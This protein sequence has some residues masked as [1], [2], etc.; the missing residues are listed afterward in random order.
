V[1][2]K[3]IVSPGTG[4]GGKEQGMDS[5]MKRPIIA[6][7]MGDPAGIGPEIILKAIADKEVMAA[8]RPLVI[9]D[10]GVLEQA[11]NFAGFEGKIR[12]VGSPNEGAYTPST[13]DL[14]DLHNVDLGS[15]Q[16]GA[17]QAM[18]GRAAFEYLVKAVELAA[19]KLVAAVTTA[20]INKE[21]LRAAKINFIG[22][23]EIFAG[24]TGVP[25]P[26]TMFQVQGLKVFFLSR[27]VSL[28]RACELVT[29]ERV[30]QAITGCLEALGRL[31]QREATLAVAGLNPHSGEHGL[32]GDEEVNQIEPAVREAR[33]RGYRVVGPVPADSVFHQALQ[34]KYD[35]V[36]SL[37]HDQGHIATKT[38]DFERTVSVTL[39]LPFLR[40]SVDHGTAFD[41]A[42]R[43][44]ASGVGMKEAILVAAKYGC[45]G[46]QTT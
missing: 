17:V 9:G 25:E 38:L 4:R 41:I 43:G 3:E 40:T 14:L 15:L 16:V 36:L 27:H 6:V 5:G 13:M 12:V 1:S 2:S 34:G 20:P 30:L 37:Y 33:R 26:L 7:T 11:R 23:T 45:G 32:F 21:S 8:C 29:R 28:R 10:R 42:G 44:I 19:S 24:L 22:H 35:A 46:G 18:C 31:G 39:G